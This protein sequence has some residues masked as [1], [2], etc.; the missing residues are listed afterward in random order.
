MYVSE[1]FSGLNLLLLVITVGRIKLLGPPI[2]S[3]IRVV[4][5]TSYPLCPSEE[6]H[7][8]VF[9]QNLQEISPAIKKKIRKAKFLVVLL[10]LCLLYIYLIPTCLLY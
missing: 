7:I 1:I 8:G 4:N 5:G 10:I 6:D 3:Y 9:A 2:I